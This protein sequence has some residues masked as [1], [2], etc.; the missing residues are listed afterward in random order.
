VGKVGGSLSVNRVTKDKTTERKD[1]NKHFTL[2]AFAG[3][4]V[5]IVHFFTGKINHG[6]VCRLILQMHRQIPVFQ[7]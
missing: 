2:D 5:N 4:L 3:G 1:S 6:H 7:V